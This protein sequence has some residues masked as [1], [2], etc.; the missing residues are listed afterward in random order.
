VVRHPKTQPVLLDQKCQV[1]VIPSPKLE[2]QTTLGNL[3]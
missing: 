1:K 3:G 2:A